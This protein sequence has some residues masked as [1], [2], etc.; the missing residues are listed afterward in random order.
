MIK[1]QERLHELIQSGRIPPALLLCGPK[2]SGKQEAAYTFAS[3]LLDTPKKIDHHPDLHLY[4]PEGKIGLHPIESIRNL[5][6]DVA[7]VPFIGKWKIFIIHEA[8]AMLPTSSNALLKTLE[9]PTPQTV[10]ILLAEHPERLLPTVVSRCYTLMF[11]TQQRN[12]LSEELLL[13]L[14]QGWN[15]QL[16]DSFEQQD[17]DQ[18]FESIHCWYRDRLLLEI[19]DTSDL[20]FSEHKTQIQQTPLI[21]LEQIEKQLRLVRLAHERGMK[22]SLCLEMFFLSC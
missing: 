6:Q 11:S 18:I 9:E 12:K 14:T 21:P 19:K 5:S 4:F 17:P 8:E 3:H 10:I 16:K 1:A 13:L 15:V 7:L 20:Y 22:L 2:E